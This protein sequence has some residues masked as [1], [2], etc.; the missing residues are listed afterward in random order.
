MQRGG[1][2]I[3]DMEASRSA[4]NHGA[5]FAIDDD[6]QTQHIYRVQVSLNNLPDWCH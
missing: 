4:K 5:L 1:H 3:Y 2:A 6:D